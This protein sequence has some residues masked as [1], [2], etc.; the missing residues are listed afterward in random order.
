MSS[1]FQ[2]GLTQKTLDTKTRHINIFGS[3]IYRQLQHFL[4]KLESAKLQKVKLVCFVLPPSKVLR[5][6]TLK[7]N[8][9]TWSKEEQGT[10]EETLL[11]LKLLQRKVLRGWKCFPFHKIWKL[12]HK[13][14]RSRWTEL[15]SCSKLKLFIFPN[16]NK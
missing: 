10:G 6:A 4:R 15:M 5:L 16:V 13:W 2:V 1:K 9:Q 14:R 8:S 12:L 3:L 11:T 7:N